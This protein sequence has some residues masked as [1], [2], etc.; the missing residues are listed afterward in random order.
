[1]Y[2]LWCGMRPFGNWRSRDI[3]NYE[4]VEFI[5]KYIIFKAATCFFLHILI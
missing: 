2:A 5:P 4:L 3:V 1:M